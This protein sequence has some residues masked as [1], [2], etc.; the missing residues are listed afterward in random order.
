MITAVDSNVLLDFLNYD[1]EFGIPSRNALRS[2][3]AEGR[4]VACDVVWAEIAAC[5]PSVS[6][7][8]TTL[9]ELEIEFSALGEDSAFEAGD[10]WAAYRRRGGSR[11]RVTADF[12]IGAH[13][14]RQADRLL[15]RDRG[16]YHAYFKKL[17]VLD[18]SA[19]ARR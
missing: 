11:S 8:R 4:V 13:A 19:R 15:T 7:C 6:D 3:A 5:F 10:Q 12:L 2:C 9:G 17:R 18:P 1:P 16:F 14:L